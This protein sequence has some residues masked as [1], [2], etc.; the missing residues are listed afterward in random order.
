MGAVRGPCPLHVLQN[1]ASHSSLLLACLAE[2]Q[3]MIPC[4]QALFARFFA[5]SGRHVRTNRT[6]VKVKLLLPPRQ[7]RGTPLGI[8]SRFSSFTS[9]F[10]SLRKSVISSCTLARCVPNAELTNSLIAFKSLLFICGSIPCGRR[11]AC[12]PSL[13]GI[14]HANGAAGQIRPPCHHWAGFLDRASGE[15]CS[16]YQEP[17][18]KLVV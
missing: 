12:W 5:G 15:H 8:R 16:L 13:G 2:K 3:S 10:S 4:W 11:R 7:S 18:A 1:S 17:P 6:A 9:C 14:D